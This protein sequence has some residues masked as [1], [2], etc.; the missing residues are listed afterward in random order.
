[1]RNSRHIRSQSHSPGVFASTRITASSKDEKK[2][3]AKDILYTRPGE[4]LFLSNSISRESQDKQFHGP[5]VS[6]PLPVVKDYTPYEVVSLPSIA[7]TL[8][9]AA[10]GFQIESKE[11]VPT[12]ELTEN[13]ILQWPILDFKYRSE[14]SQKEH[15]NFVGINPVHGFITISI[16]KIDAQKLANFEGNKSKD[17]LKAFYKRD[18]H[19]RLGRSMSRR[20]LL[21]DQEQEKHRNS[22]PLKKMNSRKKLRHT[23]KEEE[24]TNTPKDTIQRRASLGHLIPKIRLKRDRSRETTDDDST[25]AS[26]VSD[27]DNSTSNDEDRKREFSTSPHKRKIKRAIKDPGIRIRS[28]TISSDPSELQVVV[29][30]TPVNSNSRQEKISSICD[31]VN[32][33]LARR[34]SPYENSEKSPEYRG[35]LFTKALIRTHTN[36]IEKSFP[37]KITR[38]L[39]PK[40]YFKSLKQVQPDMSLFN[41]KYVSSSDI[42]DVLLTYE[43]KVSI[44]KYK[45]GVL[46]CRARQRFEE[47]MYRNSCASSDFEEFLSLLGDKVSLRNYT[48]WNAG[49]DIDGDRDGTHSICTSFSPKEKEW[50]ETEENI[51]VMFHV[52]TMLGFQEGDMQQTNR[53]KHIGNDVVVIIYT[54]CAKPFSPIFI[55]SKYNHVFLV[56]KKAQ[57]ESKIKGKTVYKVDITY[58]DGIRSFNPMFPSTQL[59]EFGEQF[60]DWLLL[61]C[62]NGERSSYGSNVFKRTREESRHHLLEQIYKNFT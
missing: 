30:I 38:N 16:L 15:I 31:E 24:S 2:T 7:K 33:S 35:K 62:I 40:Y 50:S 42:R 12:T 51:E 14:Y 3:K 46:Y 21:S 22:S 53:K 52:S 27:S 44:T 11:L 17:S 57:K 6:P 9:R 58:R 37:V 54:E 60:R 13:K 25:A 28:N 34:Q 19:E 1:M 39:K 55:S 49:L 36:D 56:V 29:N 8:I 32:R 48:G 26:P 47:D 4:S 41:M 61:K 5:H 43:D 18:S 20:N 23:E 10:P 45:F 59:F